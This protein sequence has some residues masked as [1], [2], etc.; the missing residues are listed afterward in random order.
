MSGIKSIDQNTLIE[1]CLQNKEWAQKE[2]YDMYSEELYAL[3]IRYATDLNEAK[4]LLQEGFIRIFTNLHQYKSNGALIGW[5]KRVV[6]TT[7]LNYIKK[8][9]KILAYDAEDYAE[10]QPMQNDI[11]S[12]LNAKEIMGAFTQLPYHYRV[13]MSLH[14]IEGYNYKE[15]SKMLK[16][17]QST[18]RTKVHRG[19]L[20][21]Q[22]ILT[23][24]S[25]SIQ[26]SIK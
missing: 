17:E 8:H 13:V 3:C 12:N 22:N 24:Y 2:L 15:I 25:L 10:Q 6:V 1:H 19:K 16:M 23:P 18:C 7:A 14:I 21:L 26:T 9:K 11:L 4:D 5:M 20:L